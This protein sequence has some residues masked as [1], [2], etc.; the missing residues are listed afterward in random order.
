L[1]IRAYSFI[2]S[3][4]FSTKIMGLRPRTQA[5]QKQEELLESFINLK[6][7]DKLL[8]YLESTLFNHPPDL[9]C[10]SPFVL[11][12]I[13]TLASLGDYCNA[14]L[15]RKEFDKVLS[16]QPI[17]VRAANLLR[18]LVDIGQKSC[19]TKQL[20]DLERTEYNEED[21]KY[22]KYQLI[23]SLELI[24]KDNG[25]SLRPRLH[26]K[27][28]VEKPPI[29]DEF[30]EL[31]KD[32]SERLIK[33]TDWSPQKRLLE[34]QFNIIKSETADSGKESD[35]DDDDS[36][37]D[38]KSYMILKNE[39]FDIA[40]Q[41]ER[42]WSAVTWA[43]QCSSSKEKIEMEA[44]K[45][46]KPILYIIFDILSIDLEDFIHSKA[47][48][49]NGISNIPPMFTETITFNVLQKVGRH[50]PI[51]KMTD[52]IFTD[53][54]G[55]GGKKIGPIF[56]NELT[57]AKS[58]HLADEITSFFPGA[59]YSLE[60]MAFRKK[61]F[62]FV[63]KAV[64]HSGLQDDPKQTRWSTEN[65]L[66]SVTLKL[67]DATYIDFVNFF[68]LDECELSES[69][70]LD[71]LL[72][73]LLDFFVQVNT[74]KFH[75]PADNWIYDEKSSFVGTLISNVTYMEKYYDHLGEKLIPKMTSD[76]SKLNFA[77]YI[78]L[79]LWLKSCGLLGNVDD[80]HIHVIIQWCETGEEKRRNVLQKALPKDDPLDIDI[81]F[82]LTKTV[83]LQFNK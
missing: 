33:A 83:K 79:N 10:P 4:S 8:F 71:L 68:A 11:N 27:K 35:D 50:Y 54:K 61:L 42:F 49:L 26:Y 12:I 2:T 17:H 30:D 67:L 5:A 65:L 14:D 63:A 38:K 73:I 72:D 15:I 36:S 74:Y 23:K 47:N 39:R 51:S 1:L 80:D 6:Q 81:L 69:W 18:R 22:T 43:L 53:S 75:P 59:E 82:S 41:N 56:S 52:V 70:K 46:W 48:E 31:E 24:N 58:V 9:N 29:D 64:I 3:I 66:R 21:V 55:P 60:S 13:F 28:Y 16:T 32:S 45:V 19:I 76:Y 44:W 57:L 40:L 20:E 34:Q 62:Y 37:L 77:L 7:Y 25:R 78:L